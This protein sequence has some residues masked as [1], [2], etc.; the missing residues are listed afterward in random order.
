MQMICQWCDASYEGRKDSRYCKAEHQKPCDHC[1]E[2]FTIKQMKRPAKTCSKPCADEMT[3]KNKPQI[4][5]NCTIC[6]TAFIANKSTDKL[7]GNTHYKQ[8]VVCD[9][10]F[11]PSRLEPSK[12]A[13]TCSKKCAAAITDFDARNK[14]AII[15]NMEKYGVENASQIESVK[16]KKRSTSM[17]NYGIEN[18]FQHPDVRA[19][20]TKNNGK[21]ISVNNRTWKKEIYDATGID[22]TL[23]VA[24]GKDSHADLG[25]KNILI[26]FNPTAT[27]S[28]S[29]SFPHLTGRCV[30]ENC[31][32][33]NHLPKEEKYHQNRALAAEK[34]GKVLLQYFD[35][36]NKDI[37]INILKSKLKMNTNQ[38][39]ARKTTLK[40][41][42]QTD[43][44]KFFK[45]NHLIGATNGQELCLGLFYEGKMIHCQ[46]YGKARFNK[47]FEW[48]A[49]RSCSKLDYQ[50][51][52]GFS[53]CDKYFFNKI[54]PN[55][56]ISYVDLSISYGETETKFN[57]WTLYKTNNPNGVW[58]RNTNNK[59]H[60]EIIKESTAR[61]ISADRILGLEVGEKYPILDEN[62]LKITNDF[63]LK[64][65]GYL[66]VYDCGVRVFSWTKP[67]TT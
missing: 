5:K 58:V 1:G 31:T 4:D 22:F 49:I 8:C 41:I 16:A 67:I 29:V 6:G 34:E 21:T 12:E 46:T 38:I 48:E 9:N 11:A 15:T 18:I 40:E 44:N 61:R 56:V 45:E 42:S 51:Q 19:L 35:W 7:C 59:A 43:A 2:F 39:Y 65:E 63:V 28:S 27:H 50:V 32:K 53:K 26:D 33:P 60:P 55:S 17:K 54:D 37:F 30:T 23:E 13:K 64:S 66:K 20:A 14:K 36:Y 52:G 25:Y 10:S 57:N 3:S 47:N 24:F 62:G